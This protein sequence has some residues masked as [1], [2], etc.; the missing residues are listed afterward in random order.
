[1]KNLY[2]DLAKLTPKGTVKLELSHVFVSPT[3]TWATDGHY[4]VRVADEHPG[5]KHTHAIPAWYAEK[6]MVGAVLTENED[7]TLSGTITHKRNGVEILTPPDPLCE[8]KNI[9][10]V[11]DSVA[12]DLVKDYTNETTEQMPTCSAVLLAPLIEFIGKHANDYSKG[13]QIRHG[14]K[15]LP[16]HIS[17]STC[18]VEA[19]LMPFTS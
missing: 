8:V 2:K 10:D 7:C 15:K 17:D 18:K 3:H 4:A 12:W 16:V 9:V 5:W 11:I 1:M 19:V 6:C 13:V 14:G